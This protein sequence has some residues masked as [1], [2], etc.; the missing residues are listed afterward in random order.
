MADWA[1]FLVNLPLLQEYGW[2]LIAGLQV[3]AEVVAI[4]CTLGFLLAIPLGR[5]RLSRNPL[6]SGPALC[7]VTV[8]RGT[9]LLCQLYLIY[10]GA[11]ELRPALQALGLWPLFRDAFFCCIFAFT[12]NTA[13]YQAEI[14]RGAI[15]SVP[16]GQ[17]EAAAALGLSP[18]QVARRIVYPQAFLV[19]LRPLGNELISII[20]ASA[21]AAIVTLLDLMGQTRL[22]FSRTF[23]FSVYLYAALIY[24][25]MT[26]AIRRLWLVIERRASVHLRIAPDAKPHSAGQAS[27]IGTAASQIA[28]GVRAT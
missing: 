25:L 4:S 1:G 6:L 2:R 22:I 5:A 3:T 18:R 8:M 9:P 28:H 16:C 27:R 20:K 26:E 12:L 19:A 23:D 7:Y 13:A 10:Y 21:L 11:G 15:A 14:F 17:T 24:L